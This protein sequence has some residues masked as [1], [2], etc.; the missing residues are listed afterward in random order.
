MQRKAIKRKLNFYFSN[1]DLNIDH[2]HV[3]LGSN[4][5][6]R[7]DV[8]YPFSKFGVNKPL[9]TWLIKMLLFDQMFY[10]QE[11]L[12]QV[13]KSV[14]SPGQLS[15]NAEAAGFWQ[16]RVLVW[17]PVPQVNVQDDHADHSVH[18]TAPE[19]MLWYL[20]RALHNYM[21]NLGRYWFVHSMDAILYQLF[22]VGFHILIVKSLIY[23]YINWW[24]RESKT[25]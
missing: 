25:L 22:G 20:L 14:P 15:F 17:V 8:S 13:R 24:S 21:F 12:L 3:H 7:L 6:L 2:I 23:V 5:K 9:K 4:P 18:P 19:H 11:L 16:S 10:L 1:S